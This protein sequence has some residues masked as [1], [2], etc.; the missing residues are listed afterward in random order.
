M[1]GWP[2][3]GGHGIAALTALVLT[4]PV[5]EFVQIQQLSDAERRVR[6]ALP[7][8]CTPTMSASPSFQAGRVTIDIECGSETLA[9]SRGVE[10]TIPARWPATR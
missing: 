7:A 4:V 5:A 9:R 1:R 10:Q 2:R 3:L 6:F 8:T